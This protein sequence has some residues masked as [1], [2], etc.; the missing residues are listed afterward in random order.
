MHEI[1]DYI[2]VEKGAIRYIRPK[3]YTQ[4]IYYIYIY[5]DRKLNKYMWGEKSQTNLHHLLHDRVSQTYHAILH[6]HN[7]KH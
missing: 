4:I 7:C 2:N 6:L 5:I 1:K 3:E